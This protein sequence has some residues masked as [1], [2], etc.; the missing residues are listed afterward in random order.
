MYVKEE[1][2]EGGCNYFFTEFNYIIR[3]PEPK[4]KAQDWDV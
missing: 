4:R 3:T 2:D 1:E